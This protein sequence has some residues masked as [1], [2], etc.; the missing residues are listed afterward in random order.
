MRYYYGDPNYQ[1]DAEQE[2]DIP[3]QFRRILGPS[4][5]KD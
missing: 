2:I 5:V 3:D 4:R 1:P